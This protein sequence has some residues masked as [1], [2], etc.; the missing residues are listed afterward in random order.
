MFWTNVVPSACLM[1]LSSYAIRIFEGPAQARH[2]L[3]FWD[4]CWLVSTPPPP[5]HPTHGLPPPAFRRSAASR[6]T[7]RAGPATAGRAVL[8]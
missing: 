1:L 3:Y 6:A 7:G 8:R 4:Q 5:P 2:S